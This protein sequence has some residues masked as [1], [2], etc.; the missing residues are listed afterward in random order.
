MGLCRRCPAGRTAR[1]SAPARDNFGG[2]W[3]G[4][5]DRERRQMRKAVTKLRQHVPTVTLVCLWL[6]TPCDTSLT[7]PAARTRGGPRS[8]PCSDLLCTQCAGIGR[9]PTKTPAQRGSDGEPAGRRDSVS[10][11][12]MTWKSGAARRSDQIG[13][14]NEMGCDQHKSLATLPVQP[15]DNVVEAR[16]TARRVL[17]LRSLWFS[18]A[19]FPDWRSTRYGQAGARHV[20][21]DGRQDRSPQ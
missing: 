6:E 19:H 1:G 4:T 15:L 17:Y 16:P 11:T 13:S 9:A 20:V 7:Y 21:S 12:S 18:G 10:C 8:T 5:T 14:T 3:G 2:V